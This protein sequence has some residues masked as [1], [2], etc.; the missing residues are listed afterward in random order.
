[1]PQS[2]AFEA[3]PTAVVH[4]ALPHDSARLHVRGSA[5]YV[6]DIREPE[7]TLHVAV[8]MATAAAGVLTSLDLSAVKAAPG[9]VAVLTAA[10][11]PGKNDIAPVFA[12]E[13]LLVEGE[14]GRASCRE[15]VY[16]LV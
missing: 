13:P 14:I 6:D 15:R 2:D 4:K 7:G 11:V 3:A 16:V 10:D 12:D 9:V 1:M 8:G 5:T